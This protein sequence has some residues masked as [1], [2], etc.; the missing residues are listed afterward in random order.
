MN[1]NLIPTLKELHLAGAA[2]TLDVRLQEAA[3]N[4]LGHAEFLEL[5][6]KDEVNVRTDRRI[7]KRMKAACFA[8]EKTLDE[9]NWE[10]NTSV[11]RKM[12]FELATCDFARKARD[13]LFIGPP[14]V[15]KSHLAQ[16]IGIQAIRMGLTVYYRSVFD[17][18]R[19]F[20]EDEAFAGEDK[21]LKK[22]L[23][24]ELLIIDDMG[25]RQ[26]PKRSGEY[27]FEVIM[28]RHEKRSTIMTSN[29]PLDEWGKLLGDV[30]TAGAILDRFLQDAESV[31]ITGRSYRLKDKAAEKAKKEVK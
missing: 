3:A 18:V 21:V 1:N 9:F 15:G 29:R 27:L 13:V 2:S 25:L 12:I 4:R 7:S 16:A 22:Y 26:L 14:G 8:S 23:V 17:L 30:P 19:D 5:L 11:N 20:L 28:R 10:F 31:N 24:C 6:L